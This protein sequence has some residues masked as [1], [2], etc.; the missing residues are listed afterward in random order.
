MRN[1][2]VH[3][4][5][6]QISTQKQ[7]FSENLLSIGTSKNVLLNWKMLDHVLQNM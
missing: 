7:L 4:E 5:Q 1:V 6:M 2:A 3:K